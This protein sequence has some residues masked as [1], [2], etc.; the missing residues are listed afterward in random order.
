MHVSEVE[1]CGGK[2]RVLVS[3]RGE[4][5]MLLGV[6]TVALHLGVCRIWIVLFLLTQNSE[7][8]ATM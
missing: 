3:R 2:G 5:C 1:L 8:V 6:G 4:Q 7:G